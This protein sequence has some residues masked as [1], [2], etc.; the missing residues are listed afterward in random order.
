MYCSLEKLDLGIAL[1][2]GLACFIQTDHRTADEITASAPLSV[3]FAITRCLVAHSAAAQ[4]G[5]RPFRVVYQL[6]A[7]P[8]AF[9]SAAVAAAGGTIARAPDSSLA[10]TPE[11]EPRLAELAH[12]VGDAA[13]KRAAAVWRRER[14]E[15][16]LAD[17]R[18]YEGRRYHVTDRAEDEVEYYTRIATLGALA[19]SVLVP[20]LDGAT[21]K[22]AASVIPFV[23]SGRC[24]GRDYF[25][26]DVF[27]RAQRLVEH[28]AGEALSALV[29]SIFDEPLRSASMFPDTT[30][31]QLEARL[32]AG[33]LDDLASRTSA[34]SHA[35]AAADA[36]RAWGVPVGDALTWISQRVRD[37]DLP[38]IGKPIL[39]RVAD[40]SSGFDGDREVFDPLTPYHRAIERAIDRHGRFDGSRDD[41]GNAADI[42]SAGILGFRLPDDGGPFAGRRIAELPDPFGPIAAVFAL[43]YVVFS[44]DARGITL[45]A[46]TAPT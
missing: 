21:W 46:P 39:A 16:T 28:G 13:A 15:P 36:L 35:R 19:A 9:L 41:V 3:L 22:P 14:L 2:S 23:L 29:A 37:T 12:W 34:E 25:H 18:A 40:A 1:P 24:N 4:S 11:L 31:E 17:L 20:R 26:I 38:A 32:L 10:S 43:G 7:D 27:G 6:A 30:P 45:L 8:P 5:R 33:S 44:I 42:R